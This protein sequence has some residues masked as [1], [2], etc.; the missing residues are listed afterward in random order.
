MLQGVPRSE[1]EK[2]VDEL[3]VLESEVAEGLTLL[4]VG[5]VWVFDDLADV[6]ED[7]GASVS[8][9]D[10]VGEGRR[11]GEAAPGKRRRSGE[12]YRS[13]KLSASHGFTFGQDKSTVPNAIRKTNG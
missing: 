1:T 9:D 8:A 2:S 13:E 6:V 4:I 10:A 3:F 11:H 7:D 5:Q 12:D